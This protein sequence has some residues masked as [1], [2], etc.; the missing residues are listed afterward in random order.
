MPC[1]YRGKLAF[2]S[3]QIAEYLQYP[4]PL[5]GCNGDPASALR[6]Y[7]L[8]NHTDVL[9][10]GSVARGFLDRDV[11]GSTTENMLADAPCDLLLVSDVH[12][13]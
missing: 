7:V 9:A 2:F 5:P 11:I 3:L 6:K 13:P 1:F 8:S 4:V 12:S 10:M